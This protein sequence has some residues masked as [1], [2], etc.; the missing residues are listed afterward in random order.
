MSLLRNVS[1][2]IN[3]ANDSIEVAPVSR[4]PALRADPNYPLGWGDALYTPLRLL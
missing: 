2:G 3:A 4:R 1:R